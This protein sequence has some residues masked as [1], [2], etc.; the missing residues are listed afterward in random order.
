M[1]GQEGN[2][3]AK[4]AET[5]GSYAPFL[6]SPGHAQLALLADFLSPRFTWKPVRRLF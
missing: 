1:W 3:Q 6:S 4:Q 2:W 5:R